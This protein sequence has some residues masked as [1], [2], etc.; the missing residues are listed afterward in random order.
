LVDDESVPNLGSD[1]SPYE[2]EKLTRRRQCGES[3]STIATYGGLHAS[4]AAS[5]DRADTLDDTE[6]IRYI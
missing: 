6:S 4:N 3:H 2:L 1:N 5:I